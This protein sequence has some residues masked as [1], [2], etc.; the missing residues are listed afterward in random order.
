MWTKVFRKSGE[1]THGPGTKLNNQFPKTRGKRKFYAYEGSHAKKGI[2]VA[3][4]ERRTGE[5]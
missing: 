4:A 5:N 1:P 2:D 3:S